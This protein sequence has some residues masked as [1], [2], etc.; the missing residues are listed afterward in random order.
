MT[1]KE[2]QKKY[3][4]GLGHQLKP[5]L[6][7]A[8]AGLSESVLLEFDVTLSHHELIKV[9]VRAGDRENR[10][11]V[12]SDLCQQGTAQLITRIGNVALI[13]RRNEDKPKIRLPR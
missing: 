9:R 11:A 5:T 12:I 6:T 7:V 3:L 8:D 10:D 1:L 4:R 2:S 13:Y